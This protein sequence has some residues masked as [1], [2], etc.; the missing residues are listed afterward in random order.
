MPH[1]ANAPRATILVVDDDR[2]L[3]TL[4]A[5]ALRSEGHRVITAGD[6]TEALS[7]LEGTQVEL[8]VSDLAMPG[9]DGREMS[10][11]LWERRRHIPILF[12][13]SH[14]QQPELLPGAFIAKP[15]RYD[16]LLTRVRELLRR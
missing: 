10:H 12:M 15:F 7:T 4:V 6:G 5:A 11:A 8:I 14:P 16:E 3:R 2:A 13:S 9:V 1:P